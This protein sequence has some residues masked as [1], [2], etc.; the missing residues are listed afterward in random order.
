MFV[1]QVAG[2]QF[3]HLKF[4]LQFVAKLLAVFSL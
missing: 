1:L 2:V 4:C 3:G